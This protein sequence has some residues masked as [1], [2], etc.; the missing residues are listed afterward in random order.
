MGV[1]RAVSL[2]LVVVGWSPAM[3]RAQAATVGD[4]WAGGVRIGAG[5]SSWLGTADDS[6]HLGAA[7]GG[8]VTHRRTRHLALQGELLLHDKGAD[9]R[10]A[11][12]Q[13]ADEALLYLEAPLLIRYDQEVGELVSIY[14]VAGPGL[15]FLVDSKRTERGD[16]RAFDLT[17]TAGLGVDL[18]TPSRYLSIDLRVGLG[19]LDIFGD[20]ARRARPLLTSLLF[21]VEL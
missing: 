16:L 8:F 1:A 13:A 3:A 20:D 18:Y 11:S 6:M 17:A 10:D 7:L 14:G 12:G 4:P 21:G 15:A 5:V 9:F 2:V 19:L